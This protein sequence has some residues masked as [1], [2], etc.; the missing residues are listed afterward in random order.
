MKNRHL[1]FTV[2]IA[3]L[4]LLLPFRQAMAATETVYPGFRVDGRFLY[5]NQG[6]KVIL[7]GVNKMI[8]WLDKDGVPSY[9]EIA[10]TGANCVRIVW[11]L[12]ESAEDLDT[13][14]RNCRLQNMIPIIELHNA[15]GDWSKL[16]SLV[17][18]WVSPDIVKVIQKHQEYLLINIGNEVGMQVSETDFKTGYETAVNRMRDA[19][20]HVPLVID[21][22]SYGQ[23]IDILQSCGPDL[24]EADP[25]SNLMFS[26]HMWWP[27]VWGYTAQKVID[28]LEESVALNL[29]LIVGEFGNQWD[30]TESGQIAYKTILEHCYKNQ[31]GYLPWEWGPGNNPQTFLDMTTDGTYDTLNGW[32][33]EVAE[34]DTYSIHNIAERPVSMLSNLPA[35]LPAKPLLA[36]N[37]ALGKSVIASSFESNLYLSNAITDGNLDTRWA[38]K[39]TDPNWVSIDLGSVKEINRILIY[40]EAA[41]ATQYKIQVSDDNLT[42]TDIY[43]EYNGKGGTEDINLQASGRY[44]RI[45][46]M[47]RYNNNWPYS[48][49]EVGIYGPESELSASISPTTAVFDKNTN[50]QDDIAVTLSS[51]NNTLLEVKNGEISLNSDTDYAVEDNILRIKKEYLEKQPVGTILLTLNYNEGVAPMLAIA[52][53]DTTS[54]PYIRPGRAEFNETNQEDIVVTLTENGHNL[55]EIKNGTD[56]LISGTDYTIS[57]DQVTIKKEY[58]AKQ[59]AGITRLTFDY[60][61]NFNPALKINVS[62]NTSSNNSVISPAAS[63]YEKNLSKDITVTLTLNSNTLLSILNGSNALISDSDYTMS[64]NV[65]TLKKDY[66][67]SLPVGKNTLTFIFSEGLSQVLTIKVTEQKETTE[68]GL[69]IESYHGTTTDTTNT[70][71]PKFRITNTGDKAISL[72]D[73]KIRYY[74]TKDGDQEQ[75]FWCDWSNI[76]A[77]NVTGT[78][79]TMDNKTENADNYFEIGFSSEANQLDVN[80]S[81]EVQIR[82]AK[83]DWSNYNQSNDYSFQD[84]ANNY[85]IC[86][87]ITAYISESLCYGME[88]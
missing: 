59:S 11:S 31:I 22:S 9:S 37:L 50:N 73:V 85:A 69:L 4:F 83:T 86:D 68:A 65:V 41:Y 79:V 54:S 76:G 8:V 2:L 77:S 53:G 7:Y 16:S 67:D 27:K 43:S 44:I 29:P 6:E 88:P 28:E 75:S 30:E 62:K 33:L 58:L 13:T 52:V 42:Y 26:I 38:S 49:Y 40:W 47:Q 36:G 21:A 71:S 18:Y 35:V 66:L 48:I 84:N 56:A 57:D 20:I 81:I 46:G 14:I 64:D 17:D 23:N 34:T 15:T 24:I 78:F 61:L 45:Y 25:D 10:K 1:F 51:K 72:S 80:K 3:I 19:G 74:Y 70:I 5:D 60:N 55:I 32:G 39:V 82:I 63:V 12:D 87:K